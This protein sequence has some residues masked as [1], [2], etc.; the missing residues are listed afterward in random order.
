MCDSEEIGKSLDVEIGAQTPTARELVRLRG[1]VMGSTRGAGAITK[2]AQ[3]LQTSR[4]TVSRLIAPATIR[5]V[6]R[7]ER[8]V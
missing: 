2:P 6:A 3:E 8:H 1:R 4:S 7:I 5:L